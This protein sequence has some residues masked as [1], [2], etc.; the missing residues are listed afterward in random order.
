MEILIKGEAKEI[1]ALV[2]EIQG[3]QKQAVDIVI[4]KEKIATCLL[5]NR[6]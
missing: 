5:D 3:R 1:A 6:H 4:D 2:A